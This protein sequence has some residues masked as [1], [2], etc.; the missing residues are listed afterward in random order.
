MSLFNKIKQYLSGENLNKDFEHQNPENWVIGFIYFNYKDY[1]FFVPKKNPNL[2]LTLNLAHP[3]AYIF[4]FI[5][6]LRILFPYLAD[7]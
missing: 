6:S 3:I 5:V 1:R 4:L 2:G 7:K